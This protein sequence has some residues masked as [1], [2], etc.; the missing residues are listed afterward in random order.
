MLRQWGGRL[1]IDLDPKNPLNLVQLDDGFHADL[2]FHG[3]IV[4]CT[5][6]WASV[7]A[8]CDRDTGDGFTAKEAPP[9]PADPWTDEAERPKLRVIKGGKS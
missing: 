9:V 1:V 8:G 7:W 6:P 2:S 5:I 4:K 3:R